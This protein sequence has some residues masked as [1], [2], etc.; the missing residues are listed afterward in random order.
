MAITSIAE[1]RKLYATRLAPDGSFWA[2]SPADQVLV[3]RGFIAVL[4]AKPGD[5]SY[6]ISSDTEFEWTE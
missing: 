5:R 3:L 2:K 6:D 1:V 4:Q